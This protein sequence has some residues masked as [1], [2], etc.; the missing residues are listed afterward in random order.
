MGEPVRRAARHAVDEGFVA[1]ANTMPD[2][3]STYRGR[4]L[5]SSEL[6]EMPP[7][8]LKGSRT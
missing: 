5:V 4:L 1:I 6:I 3:A 2:E 8:K 7:K